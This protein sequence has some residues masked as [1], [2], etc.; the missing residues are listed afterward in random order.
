MLPPD[1]TTPTV[2]PRSSS[3]A[4]SRAGEA[5]GA[6]PLHH[7]LLDLQ[8]QVDGALHRV[9]G[10]G[11]QLVDVGVH[12]RGG[13]G[14]RDRHGDP[15]GH[16]GAA[17]RRDVAADGAEHRRPALALHPDHHDVGTQGLGDDGHPR[18]EP[19]ATDRHDQRVDLGVVGQQLEGHGALAGHDGGVVVGVDQRAALG[20]LDPTGLGGGA[21][22]VGAGQHHAGAEHL[23]AVDLHERGGGRHHDR[24]VDAEPHGVS[25]N[26]LGVVAGGH[27]HHARH[28]RAR[29]RVLGHQEGEAVGRAALL[30]RRGE[31]QVLVLEDDR[32]AHHVAEGLGPGAG[33]PLDGTGDALG[34]GL[35]V[36]Q[37][38]G[39]GG[40]HRG[41]RLMVASTPAPASAATGGA[42][43]V[44]GAEGTATHPSTGRS[45]SARSGSK[46]PRGS[47]SGGGDELGSVAAS[48]ALAARPIAVSSIPPTHTGTPSSTHRSTKRRAA[49][50]PPTRPG[51]RQATSQAPR[52]TAASSAPID[53]RGSSR[54]IGRGQPLGEA[55]VADEVVGGQRLLEAG[56]PHRVDGLELA[57]GGRGRRGGTSRWR[58]PAARRRDRRGPAA[59]PA[60]RGGVPRRDLQAQARGAGGQRR[61]GLGQER[62][63]VGVDPERGAGGDGLR[64]GAQPGG[65]RPTGGPELRVEHRQL[66]RGPGGV[67]AADRSRGAARAPRRRPPARSRRAAARWSMSTARSPAVCS[68]A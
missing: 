46:R 47:R 39:V 55:G 3:G 10:D 27:R 66:E 38:D 30:E 4:V 14:A 13:H 35:D 18:D 33:R 62:L 37:G 21:G 45:G 16:G 65:Q 6:R 17:R 52:A 60:G 29:R 43:P 22:E 57:G 15:V 48:A 58:R 34:G 8:Q 56:E 9:V 26:G 5:R 24:G 25:G 28:L 7:R 50:Q 12:Q 53:V 41:R 59:R 23:G 44:P 31:L 42:A 54:Q 67:V 36:G 32:Q 2:R 61:V 20:G 49:G 1:S 68:G 11:D 19:T 51:F 64:G 63:L 40:A